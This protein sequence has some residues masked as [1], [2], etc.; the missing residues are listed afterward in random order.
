MASVTFKELRKSYGDTE[1]VKG[2]DL[3]IEH[4]EF[5][6]LLG[7][8]G[9]GK[10]TTLR[11][12]AGLEDISGGEIYID[13]LLV[14]DLHPIE[15][16]IAMVFQSYALY[17]HMTVEENI[18]FALENMNVKKAQRKEM[19]KEVAEVLELTPLLERKPRDLSGGQ[20]QRVAMG[21]AMVRTPKVFLFDEP[22]SNL[23]AKLRGAMRKE[24]KALHKR[25]KTTVIYVTH[26]QVEAMTLAD[27]VV[28]LNNGVIE[29]IGTPKE[30]FETPQTLYV[31]KFIGSPE[32]NI[33]PTT[34]SEFIQA[35]PN[36]VDEDRIAHIGI[37][38]Q[39]FTLFEEE[40]SSEFRCSLTLSV[41]GHEVLG[42]VIHVSAMLGSKRVTIEVAYQDEKLADELTV[43]FDY[44]KVHA[45]GT[46]QKTTL[47]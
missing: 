9:C 15:R 31:A 4:G 29:Q 40:I 12:L 47:L 5:V 25:V 33:I 21:R 6:V 35:L 17:P 10:S 11:M 13:D 34:H 1:V 24:I 27:R 26:D 3:E 37:R 45:F 46:D 20:R 30:I 44:R 7:S 2:V 14:N 28:I 36:K 32:M 19:V 23:D 38:P 42:S 16:N 22:L 39:D 41:S 43:Y 8:S 18:G